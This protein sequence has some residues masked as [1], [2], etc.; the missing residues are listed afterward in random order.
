MAEYEEVDKIYQK[1][2]EKEDGET[3]I[4]IIDTYLDGF[5]DTQTELDD[6]KHDRYEVRINS[7]LKPDEHEDTALY[8]TMG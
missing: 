3:F 8:T 4:Y 6:F 5:E 1:A 7:P 2:Y